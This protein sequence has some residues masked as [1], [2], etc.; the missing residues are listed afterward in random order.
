VILVLVSIA[1]IENKTAPMAKVQRVPT[2]VNT[3]KVILKTRIWFADIETEPWI[4]ATPV[5]SLEELVNGL[6]L[7]KNLQLIATRPSEIK[8]VAATAGTK[9]VAIPAAI[10]LAFNNRGCR[11]GKKWTKSGACTSASPTA[12]VT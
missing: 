7:H 8:I 6:G 3:K 4:L 9:T 1:C 5:Q 2:M 10:T 12:A 11:K